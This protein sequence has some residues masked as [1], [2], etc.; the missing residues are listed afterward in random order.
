MHVD[1]LSVVGFLAGSAPFWAIAAILIHYQL[2][3]AA[4][5]RNQ[6]RGGKIGGFYPS[7]LAFGT[8]LLF[9]GVFYR[10]SV[11]NVVEMKIHQ[12]AD[13]DDSGDPETL[14]KQLDR[15]LRR[16]RIGEPVDRLVLRL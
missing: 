1:S 7:S 13:E 5:R 3:R 4:G 14:T 2:R 8:A 11:A 16:I 15:Q 9:S 12:E 10:P 6:R